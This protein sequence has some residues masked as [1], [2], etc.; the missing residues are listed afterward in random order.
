ML[1]ARNKCY[2]MLWAFGELD[3]CQKQQSWQRNDVAVY[4][5][6]ERNDD[7]RVILNLQLNA[8]LLGRFRYLWS[9]SESV[10]IVSLV[11]RLIQSSRERA[12]RHAAVDPR[13]D[14]RRG[15]VGPCGSQRRRRQQCR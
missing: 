4:S 15:V 13:D 14:G 8:K 12:V 10:C 7:K 2:V 5:S 11:P 1:V 9:K 6:S 3:S